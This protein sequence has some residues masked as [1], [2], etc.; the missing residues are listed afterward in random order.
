LVPPTPPGG[1]AGGSGATGSATPLDPN[2]MIG[3]AGYGTP[4]FVAVTV[5]SLPYQIEFENAASATAPAQ[6]VTITDQLD[7]NLDWTTFQLGDIGFGT[8]TVNIPPGRTSFQTRVDATATL[9]VF[10]DVSASFNVMTGVVTW[11]FTALDP[12]TFDL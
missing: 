9:G 7:P 2:A 8:F 4:N 1:S 12:T 11:I 6:D 10:V 3:P 5:P